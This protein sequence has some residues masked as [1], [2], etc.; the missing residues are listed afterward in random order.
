MLR[1]PEYFSKQKYGVPYDYHMASHM[2]R[3]SQCLAIWRTISGKLNTKETMKILEIQ[4]RDEY[5]NYLKILQ[6]EKV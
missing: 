2:I 3:K 4:H 1:S 6:T 5:G